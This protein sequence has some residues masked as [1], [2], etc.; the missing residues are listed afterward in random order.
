ME[1]NRA[2]AFQGGGCAFVPR[3]LEAGVYT[4]SLI[5]I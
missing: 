1:E 4:L 5:H 3:L 2:F